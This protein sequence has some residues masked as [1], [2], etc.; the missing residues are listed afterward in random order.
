MGRTRKMDEIDK[1]ILG[2][3]SGEIKD[4]DVEGWWNPEDK[5]RGSREWIVNGTSIDTIAYV[6][7]KMG[8]SVKTPTVRYH[9]A[10]LVDMGYLKR[11]GAPGWGKSYRYFIVTEKEKQ[12]KI[13]E[14]KDINFREKF[15]NDLVAMLEAVNV[16]TDKWVGI[17]TD[18]MIEVNAKDLAHLLRENYAF[19]T[20]TTDRTEVVL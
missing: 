18:G 4:T 14:E 9:I 16:K 2:T 20:L 7:G 3:M 17:G 1:L 10:K 13:S 12:E 8:K 6:L 5:K 19:V 15:T 11:V